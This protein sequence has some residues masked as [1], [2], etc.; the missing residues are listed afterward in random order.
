MPSRAERSN[1]EDI[2]ETVPTDAA[3]RQSAPAQKWLRRAIKEVKRIAMAAAVASV[4][5]V[6]GRPLFARG[7]GG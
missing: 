3:A 5:I 1:I 4:A 2:V 7:E 6:D